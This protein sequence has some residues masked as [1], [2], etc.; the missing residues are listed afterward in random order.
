MAFN[1]SELSL[2]AHTGADNGNNFWFYANSAADN[3][4]TSGFFND[5]THMLRQGDLIYRV[6]TGGSYRVTS[7]TGAATVTAALISTVL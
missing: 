7:A 6:D 5:A 3:I 1:A 2:M 4:A